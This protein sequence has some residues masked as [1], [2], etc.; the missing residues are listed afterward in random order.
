[1]Q[2]HC[3]ELHAIPASADITCHRH[4]DWLS[5]RPFP[6]QAALYKIADEKQERRN[7]TKVAEHSQQAVPVD[8]QSPMAQCRSAAATTGHGS[9]SRRIS[10]A[11]S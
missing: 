10:D 2:G 3:A 6:V 9:C 1:M 5:Q 7:G 8:R 4:R 11:E